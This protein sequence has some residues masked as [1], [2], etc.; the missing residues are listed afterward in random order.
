MTLVQ[1]TIHVMN[2]RKAG[3]ETNVNFD[4]QLTVEIRFVQYLMVLVPVQKAGM[5]KTVIIH[6][7]TNVIPALIIL[8]VMYA[9]SVG[10][11][12]F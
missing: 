9:Y 2:V 8:R 1:G 7:L 10:N 11:I 12:S 6:V 4:A 5:E 3:L